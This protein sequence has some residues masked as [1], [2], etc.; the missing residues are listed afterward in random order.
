MAAHKSSLVHPKYKTKYRV[1]NWSEYERGLR[2]RGDVTIWLTE[3]AIEAW[4]LA[5]REASGTCEHGSH[6]PDR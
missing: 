1:G 3:E 6:P 2:S 4:A 5:R